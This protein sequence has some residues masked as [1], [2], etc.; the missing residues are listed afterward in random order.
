[1]MTQPQHSLHS[2]VGQTKKREPSAFPRISTL[3]RAISRARDAGAST[4]EKSR[5]VLARIGQLSSKRAGA[6]TAPSYCAITAR[7]LLTGSEPA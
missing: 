6:S 1:M 5:V 2:Y 3:N 4:L 7:V